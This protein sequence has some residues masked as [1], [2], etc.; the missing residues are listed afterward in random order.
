MS[1]LAAS[2]SVEE[3][4]SFFRVPKDISLELSGGLTFSTVGQADNA[5]S[6]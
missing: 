1:S 2:M 6:P 5:V 4:R 3:S